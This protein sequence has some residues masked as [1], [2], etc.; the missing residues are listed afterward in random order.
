MTLLPAQRGSLESN[1]KDFMTYIIFYKKEPLCEQFS[2]DKLV[3][4]TVGN[5]YYVYV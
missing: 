5:K 2:T 1:L 3:V 4:A